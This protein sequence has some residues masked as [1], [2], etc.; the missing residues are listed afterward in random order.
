MLCKSQTDWQAFFFFIK[1]NGR[2]QFKVI[3]LPLR[4]KNA[5]IFQS[6]ESIYKH[7]AVS[8]LGCFSCDIQVTEEKSG[9]FRGL[10]PL[11]LS[12]FFFFLITKKIIKNYF[13][14][15]QWIFFKFYSD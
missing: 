6:K 8:P 1:D 4:V 13:D 10:T 3:V 15:P 2:R 11:T 5:F 12:A 9:F 7:Q 14:M